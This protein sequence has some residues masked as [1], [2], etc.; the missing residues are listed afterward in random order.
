MESSLKKMSK[1]Q[2]MFQFKINKFYNNSEKNKNIQNLRM[3]MKKV[4]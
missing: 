3:I 2:C 4:Y 1:E